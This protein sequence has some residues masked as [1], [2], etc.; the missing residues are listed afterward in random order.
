MPNAF[1]CDNL[2]K[3]MDQA[4]STGQSSCQF[5]PDCGFRVLGLPKGGVVFIGDCLDIQTRTIEDRVFL[6][7]SVIART[8]DGKDD[9]DIRER[10]KMQI[11]GTCRER[12]IPAPQFFGQTWI[13]VDIDGER[14]NGRIEI[15][16]ERYSASLP[17]SDVT[18]ASGIGNTVSNGFDHSVNRDFLHRYVQAGGMVVIRSKRRTEAFQNGRELDKDSSILRERYI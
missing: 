15:E 7:L 17:I 3:M 18:G 2:P 1:E 5:A 16:G 11:I 4:L 14:T 9:A 10:L 6:N 12:L 13:K 8:T